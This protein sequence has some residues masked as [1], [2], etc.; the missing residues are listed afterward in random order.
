MWVYVSHVLVR[1]RVTATVVLSQVIA[2]VSVTLGRD[3]VSL[4]H[5]AET[6]GTLVN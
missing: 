3:W 4:K 5:G 1:A 6:G 2:V